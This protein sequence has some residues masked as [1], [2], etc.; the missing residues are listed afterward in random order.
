MIDFNV[1]DEYG[2]AAPQEPAGLGPTVTLRRARER[3]LFELCP[4]PIL[5]VSF[6][7]GRCLDVNSSFTEELCLTREE[8]LGKTTS[9]LGLWE[10][11]GERD[12]LVLGLAEQG[13]LRGWLTWIV[14]A[15]GRKRAV[16]VH[17]E[18][19]TLS[20]RD[21]ALV[22]G[23]DVSAAYLDLLT[24]LPNRRLVEERIARTFD[25]RREGGKVTAVLFID[26]D[27]LKAV[28][29]TLGHGAGDD[30]LKA[31]AARLC[32]ALGNRGQIGRFGGDELVAVLEANGPEDARAVAEGL[33][34]A[35]SR[36]LTL[37][38]EVLRPSVSIG[39]AVSAGDPA[40]SH[41]DLL[42]RAD[43]AMFRAKRAAGSHVALYTAE[44]DD[45]ALDGDE[46]ERDLALAVERDQIE[47]HYQPIVRVDDL[48]V[49]GVE[50]LARWEHPRRGEVPP[51]R[52][53]PLAESSG[54]IRSLGRN[55][56][57]RACRQVAQW[58]AAGIVEPEFVVSVN[59]SA[60]QL[61][62]RG[63][64]SEAAAILENA[65]LPPANLQL[66]ITER[67]AL[68]G[69]TDVSGLEALGVQLT[70]DDFGEGYGCFAYLRS[71]P[72]EVIK[73]DRS[74][75][76]AA[77]S[78]RVDRELMRSMIQ[79]A[80]A[81]DKQVVAEGVETPEQLRML[82]Q[83]GC[84][85]GQGFLFGEAM[86]PRQFAAMLTSRPG[87]PVVRSARRRRQG[88]VDERQQLVGVEGLR[89]ERRLP[90][91]NAPG[92]EDAVQVA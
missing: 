33:F 55:V 84:E 67:I 73:I 72:I 8:V 29:D 1:N 85:L 26:V 68:D 87:L 7:D 32:G 78:R 21:C 82:R 22:A 23:L 34:K 5:L 31:I 17:A 57:I 70:V 52:F 64:A 47:V 41:L 69:T 76:A 90:S 9:E 39:V 43:T 75:L 11:Q 10:N 51:S 61:M 65:G 37:G 28:N 53:I 77:P 66:E 71:L 46:L 27:H 20:G 19:L 91:D 40:I 35:V 14:D 2:G 92:E 48:S 56:L 81:L 25:Q 15:R 13:R 88:A 38:R 86:P 36:P 83:L 74:F 63:F 3:T 45:A 24:G 12:R 59:V 16:E 6:P 30:L 44:L 79:L 54:Q 60:G 4:L 62:D 49:V 58:R 18:R 80:K 42:R 50:A 89:E